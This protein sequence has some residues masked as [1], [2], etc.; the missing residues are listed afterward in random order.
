MRFPCLRK[1]ACSLKKCNN[2]RQPKPLRDF[3]YGLSESFEIAL[4]WFIECEKNKLVGSAINSE[5]PYHETNDCNDI[6]NREFKMEEEDWD[7]LAQSETGNID[8]EREFE[9]SEDDS[10][11]ESDDE[12]S[13]NQDEW[14]EEDS[15]GDEDE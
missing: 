10:E 15:E 3:I 6:P 7:A 11:E 12:H 14:M 13:D 4:G 1:S 8:A 9:E 2:K 5:S